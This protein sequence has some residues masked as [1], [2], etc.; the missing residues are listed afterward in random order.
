MARHEADREDLMNEATALTRRVE[1]TVANESEP[2]FA[3]YRRTG[4]LSIYFGPDPAYHFDDQGRLRRAFAGGL[5]YRTQGT[6][7]AQLERQRTE[8]E[9][10]LQRH[11]LTPEELQAFLATLTNRLTGFAAALQRNDFEVVAQVPAEGNLIDDLLVSLSQI[12]QDA[13]ALSPPINPRR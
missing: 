13:V 1:C 7:L 3:G 9:T 5:L 11:D 4:F 2:V 6:T 8:D 10:V 12:V